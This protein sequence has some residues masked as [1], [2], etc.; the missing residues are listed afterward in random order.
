MLAQARKDY[1]ENQKVK[2][3]DMLCRAVHVIGIN[4]SE[5]D[6]AIQQGKMIDGKI[7]GTKPFL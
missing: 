2:M 3:N 5:H 1:T 7:H 4:F 6:V